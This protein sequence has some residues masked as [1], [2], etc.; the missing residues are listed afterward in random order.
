MELLQ[1]GVCEAEFV[2]QFQTPLGIGILNR[3][4][5]TQILDNKKSLIF[6]TWILVRDCSY[7]KTYFLRDALKYIFSNIFQFHVNC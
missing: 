6:G 3:D 5:R 1:G 2:E 4:F 7:L